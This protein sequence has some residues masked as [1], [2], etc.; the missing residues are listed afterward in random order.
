MR[1]RTGREERESVL[2]YTYVMDE[3]LYMEYVSM[4]F[5]SL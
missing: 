2:H 5:V 3:I 4:L 1:E